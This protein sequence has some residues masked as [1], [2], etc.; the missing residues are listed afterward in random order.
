MSLPIYVI[1]HKN[2]DTDS[3]CA[4]LAL[5]ELK[6]QTGINAVAARLGTLNPETKFILDKLHVNM[7]VLLTTARSTLEEIEI[8]DAVTIEEGQTIR[9]AWDL[10]L[11]NHVKT[12]YVVD[13]KN[14]YKGMVTLG[15]VSKI[16]MQDLNIT[17]E[18][19]KETPL[20]NLVASVKGSFILKGNLERSGFVRIADK[21]LMDR[22]LKGAIMV[23]N[24]HE[25]SM[26]KSMAKG[27]AVIVVA[28]NFV[29]NSYIIEMAKQMGVTLISTSYNIMKII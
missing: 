1:G 21:R 11:E 29:P 5:A 4:A 8:D 13:D 27:C 10:C 22:D 18:L 3:I 15:D 23:L 12:L 14:E 2:P 7:P 6:R 28:E 24:D 26:I 16:Q 17:S 25:D 19:L 9:R 20:E